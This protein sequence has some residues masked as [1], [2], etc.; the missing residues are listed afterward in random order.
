VEFRI[1]RPVPH[2]ARGSFAGLEHY[3]SVSY[4]RDARPLRLAG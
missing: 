1:H 4:L 2:C 3:L